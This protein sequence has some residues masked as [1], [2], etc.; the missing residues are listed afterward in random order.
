MRVSDE[1][2]ERP[3]VPTYEAEYVPERN[4]DGIRVGGSGDFTS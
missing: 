1:E 4:P 3:N 2:P